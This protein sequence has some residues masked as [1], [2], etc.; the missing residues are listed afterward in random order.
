MQSLKP[1]QTTPTSWASRRWS[2]S[3]DAIEGTQ[4]KLG[5]LRGRTFLRAAPGGLRARIPC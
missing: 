5:E 3:L 4:C 2:L 1:S